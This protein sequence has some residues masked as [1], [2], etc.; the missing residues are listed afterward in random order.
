M[1]ARPL[2]LAT[3]I[4]LFAAL[5][6]P[7]TA[8]GYGAVV[9]KSVPVCVARA[10]AGMAARTVLASDLSGFDCASRQADFGPGD[11]WVVSRAIPEGLRKN[12]S[13]YV[14]STSG[15][16]RAMILYAL[17]PDGRVDY[18]RIDDKGATR[19]LQ[20]GTIIQQ[21]LKTRDQV[22]V[23]LAWHVEGATN[24][25]GILVGPRI[26]TATERTKANLVMAT[27]YSGFAGLLLTLLVHNTAMWRVLRQRFQLWYLVMLVSLTLYAICSSGVLAW[28]LPGI[29]NTGRLRLTYLTL[30]LSGAAAIQFSRSFLEARIFTGWLK[31]LSDATIVVLLGA[32]ATIM[33]APAGWIPVLDQIYAVG[34]LMLVVLALPIVI[35]AREHKSRF[36][37]VWLLVWTAPIFMC[38]VRIAQDLQL[39]EWRFW[40]QNSTLIAMTLEALGASL[41][42]AYRVRLLARERD[43]A[44]AEEIAARLLADADPLTGLLNR[45]AF[46]SRAIGREGPQVLLILDLDRF[47][48]VNETIGHDGGDDVLRRVAD[49]LRAMCPDTGLV[50]RFGGEEFALL[51]PI[52]C[53]LTADMLLAQLRETRMPCDLKITAS[54]GS[55]IGPVKSERDWKALYRGA[56]LALFA[57]KDAGRDRSRKGTT[58]AMLA[59]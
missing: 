54:V 15:W 35:R 44:R 56:D 58:L 24:S 53:P 14:R 6:W 20:L 16:Q 59:A 11:Y 30:A 40:I 27:L 21:Q 8:H 31:H 1:H 36:M 41:A 9:G 45:R 10:T 33:V 48:T 55:C 25:R 50:T 3:L 4:G 22:P 18:A 39:I 26:A 34:L 32:A 13:L 37:R 52:D 49:V 43:D 17:Y 57:A 38:T 5:F 19:R 7:T 28:W 12:S 51:H 46:M 2:L 23:R 47:K 29:P 42:I